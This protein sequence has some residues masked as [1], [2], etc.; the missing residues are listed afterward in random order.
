[1]WRDEGYL[2]DILNAALKI[3]L[4]ISQT[5]W[6]E[7]DKDDM[8]SDAVVRRMEIIGEASKRISGRTKNSHPE[9]DW[10]KIIGMRNRLIHEYFRVDK[11]LVWSTAISDIPE[12]I[13]LIQPLI[14]P[15][16]NDKIS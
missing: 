2:L 6:E 7:F 10:R 13:R 12:L 5:S 14:P 1:M 16:V 11:Q 4:Y 8:I 3:Q 9:L 15:Q